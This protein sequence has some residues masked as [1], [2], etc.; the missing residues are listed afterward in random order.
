[1]PQQRVKLDELRERQATNR[2][3]G[4]KGCY[5]KRINMRFL[6]A[7]YDYIKATAKATGKTLTDV[8]NECIEYARSPEEAR[9]NDQE[10]Q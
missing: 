10:G 4:R 3:R 9:R 6:P 8:C 2:T 5:S 7:N 1:M